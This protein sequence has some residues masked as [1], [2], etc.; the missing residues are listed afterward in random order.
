MS[1]PQ[2]SALIMKCKYV[3]MILVLRVLVS[4]LHPVLSPASSFV[5]PTCAGGPVMLD[6]QS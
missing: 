5:A 1:P 6:T 3:Q 2:V 4:P